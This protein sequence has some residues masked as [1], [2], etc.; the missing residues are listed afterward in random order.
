M[1][2]FLLKNENCSLKNVKK[3]LKLFKLALFLTLKKKRIIVFNKFS[4]IN[5]SR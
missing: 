2:K 5:F 3:E 1:D 4:R